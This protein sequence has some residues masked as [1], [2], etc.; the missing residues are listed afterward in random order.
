MTSVQNKTINTRVFLSVELLKTFSLKEMNGFKLFI[1]NRYI[2]VDTDL[3]VLLKQLIRFALQANKF[4]PEL[5]FNIYEQVF[6]K[7][8]KNQTTLNKKQ[9]GLLVTKLNK[10][11]RL[12][13]KFL[14][15]ETIKDTDDFNTSLLFPE[16]INRNQMMLYSRR[17]KA[18]EKKLA[19][20]KKQ[21]LDY[22]TQCYDIQK[23]KARLLFLNNTL[24]KE[25]NYD[26]LQYHADLKYL[27]QKLQYHLAKIT[28]QRN[29]AHKTFD[30][31]PFT[32]LQV[33]LNLSQYQSNPLIQIYVLNIQLVENEEEITFVALSKLV[34]E[35]QAVIPTD[36][37]K[38]FYINLT[39]YC[40]YQVS[41]GNLN[42]YNYLFEI[43]N[44]M[45]KAKLLA[46]NNTIELAL[47]KNMITN[48]CRVKAFDWAVDKLS[49]YI[50][51]IPS[52]IRNSV[53]K[54]NRG[55]IAFNQQKY[56]TVLNHFKG[57]RK[58]DDTHELSLRITQLQ[59]FYE[60]DVVYEIYT[61]Q[62][63][64]S[65][66]TYIHQNKKLTKRKK[67]GYFN[68]IRVFDK[69]YKLNTMSHKSNQ[70]SAIKKELPKLKAR[71]LKFDLIFAKQWL[72]SKIEILESGL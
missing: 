31:I 47:L 30:L 40:I 57:V 11:L 15:F 64:E 68:L 45:H 65:L 12:A 59:C 32:A 41:K 21:G 26:A 6:E 19:A 71:L 16:L 17:L 49:F 20:E 43:Y 48:A 22:H 4:T 60:L 38:P 33:L 14:M 53:F 10:L 27:L 55:I 70:L 39:N 1:A 28:L 25:D 58:I 72:L 3:P 2:N 62:M 5:Q 23:E 54:Y 36:F 42:Y 50:N 35:K 56:E 63:L 44:D 34:K 9:S 46:I 13:E 66:R 51:Y 24:V 29:Y 61:Q 18:T 8:D 69:L 52:T 67:T 7:V 37:L